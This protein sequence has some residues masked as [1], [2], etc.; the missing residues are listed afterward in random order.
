MIGMDVFVGRVFV[1]VCSCFLLYVLVHEGICVYLGKKGIF[2]GCSL[3]R[4]A[5]GIER[6]DGFWMDGRCEMDIGVDV[7]SMMGMGGVFTAEGN[8]DIMHMVSF[9]KSISCVLCLE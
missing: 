3:G 6:T 7:F 4:R 1:H 5:Y 9:V 2:N 8:G